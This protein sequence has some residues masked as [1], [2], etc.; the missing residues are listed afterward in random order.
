VADRLYTY[1]F[2]QLLIEKTVRVLTVVFRLHWGVSK[3][4]MRKRK[5]S[6]H[7]SPA[8]RPFIIHFPPSRSCLVLPIPGP[9]CCCE[10][11]RLPL[12]LFC[13]DLVFAFDLFL[14]L[15]SLP[16]FEDGFCEDDYV[17]VFLVM[18]VGMIE[19][20]RNMLELTE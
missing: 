4:A 20:V 17:V 6:K 16:L 2:W 14:F 18:L 1:A 11:W 13:V 8:S 3:H 15:L 19:S 5:R 7:N 9:A 12:Q 10:H